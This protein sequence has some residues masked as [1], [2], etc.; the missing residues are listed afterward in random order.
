MVSRNTAIVPFLGLRIWPACEAGLTTGMRRERVPPEIRKKERT[1]IKIS[2]SINDGT[3]ILISYTFFDNSSV[4]RT[5]IEDTHFT[6]WSRI[7]K[8]TVQTAYSKMAW[9]KTKS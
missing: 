2:D 6:K 7:R 4:T 8:I 3:L 5:S 1:R 9:L